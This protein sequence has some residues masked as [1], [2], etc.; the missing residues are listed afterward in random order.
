MERS[1]SD[2]YWKF[3]GEKITSSN[4]KKPQA[5]EDWTTFKLSMTNVSENDVGEYQCVAEV[6]NYPHVNKAEAS[7]YFQLSGRFFWFNEKTTLLFFSLDNVKFFNSP[8]FLESQIIFPYCE[9]K[10]NCM[11]YVFNSERVMN[12]LTSAYRLAF[13]PR[14]RRKYFNCGTKIMIIKTAK[15]S[16]CFYK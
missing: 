2:I 1:D 9:I 5:N 6:D 13:I 12:L 16:S 7:I 11:L 8:E 4:I 15:I 3:N 10:T 14:T